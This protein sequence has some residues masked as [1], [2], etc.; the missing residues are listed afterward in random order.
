M[1]HSGPPPPYS[2]SPLD[3]NST[4]NN[5]DS[6]HN[7]NIDTSYN[8]NN[9]NNNYSS[10]SSTTTKEAPSYDAVAF[11]PQVQQ[12]EATGA[13]F[14]FQDAVLTS[15]EMPSELRA[16]Q[17]MQGLPN[18][19]LQQLRHYIDPVGVGFVRIF[20]FKFATQTAADDRLSCTIVNNHSQTLL[21]TKT[22]GALETF[23][24]MN[25][26]TVM[27]TYYCR[28]SSSPQLRRVGGIIVYLNGCPVIRGDYLPHSFVMSL[29]VNCFNKQFAIRAEYFGREGLIVVFGPS[30]EP[31]MTLR[32]GDNLDEVLEIG[33]KCELD[34]LLCL[35]IAKALFIMESAQNKNPSWVPKFLRNCNVF[36]V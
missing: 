25:N 23:R 31:W 5:V 9:N 28:R 29:F 19:T 3:Y 35:V 10:S 15:L 1:A 6:N 34:G 32:S 33:P 13:A 14:V 30:N 22:Q 27:N 20:V 17:N 24:D 11:N 12:P 7:N 4:Q 8:N 36:L 26:N 16:A 2:K 18:E 21:F